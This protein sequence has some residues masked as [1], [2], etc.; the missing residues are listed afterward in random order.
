VSNKA[1]RNIL[2]CVALLL[3]IS[4]IFPYDRFNIPILHSTIIRIVMGA[5]AIG[6]G[7]RLAFALR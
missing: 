6:V 1:I 3:L 2:V 4:F 7:V 5:V